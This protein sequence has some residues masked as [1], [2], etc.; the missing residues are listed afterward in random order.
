M[1]LDSKHCWQCMPDSSTK[2]LRSL[3]EPLLVAIELD[4]VLSVPGVTLVEGMP[5]LA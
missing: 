4:H 1:Y 3:K 5:A 2:D